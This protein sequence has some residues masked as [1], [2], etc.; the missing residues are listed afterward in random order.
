MLMDFLRDKM[1]LIIYI[2]I[3]AFVGGG[4]LVYLN[5]GNTGGAN[6]SQVNAQS[7]RPIAT[8]NGDEISNQAF[9]SQV[10]RT[11]SQMR[12][13]VQDSQVLSLK[14]RVLDQLIDRQLIE[15][16][17]KER[18]LMEQ[19]SDKKIEERLDKIVQD[20][21]FN[22]KE[23]LEQRL[24]QAGRSLDGIRS[25]LKK[26]LAMQK[27]FD[28]VLKDIE[29]T[30][31]EVAENYEEVSASHILI[32]TKNKSDQKAK[33]KAEEALEEIEAGTEFSKVAKEYSEG[34]SAKKGG[35]LGS[36][37][38]GKMVKAFE[39]EAFNLE[40]GEISDPIKTKFGY[41][42]IKV[43][44][45]KEAEGE[46]FENQ[47]SKI[48]N[49]LLNEKKKKAFDKW[50]SGKRDGAEVV[51]NSKEIK[52]Y[53]A[54]QAENYEQAIKSYK[55]AL[56]E[57]GRASYLYNNL[58]QSYQKQE[59][60][61]KAISTYEEAIEKYPE[62]VSFYNSL[63]NLYQQQDQT[64]KAISLYQDALE[65]N[66]DNANLHLALGELYRKEEMKDKALEQYDKFSK[67][68]GDNLMAHYRLYSVYKKMGL[69]E[70]AQ[71]EMKKVKEIQAKKQKQQ[72]SQKKAIQQQQQSQQQNK[73]QSN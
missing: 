15:Q 35:K 13:R 70:K 14:K 69:T 25:Q 60:T 34:P 46:E 41:H 9:Q 26:S 73:K 45:K 28:E 68:S 30:D 11:L 3:I 7:D 54:Q 65:K 17:M 2:V 39:D 20:S 22:S 4:T 29:I 53:N 63:A 33:Q 61:D 5:Y 6:Q 55:A 57:N 18:G 10:N 51:I 47:K 49:K 24:K 48:K 32:R 37:G 8:V 59:K 42:V 23:E 36:F 72:Q 58:A 16:E 12:G 66:K 43:T 52:G 31:K 21:K 44:D 19:V 38:H 40:E 1:K 27:L 50:I 62:Q 64:D 67:L 71:T 56:E